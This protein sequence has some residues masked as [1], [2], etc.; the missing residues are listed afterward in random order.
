[1]SATA[2][3]VGVRAARFHHKRLWLGGVL[4]VVAAVAVVAIPIATAAHSVSIS[5]R[6]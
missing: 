6:I 5:R 2:T 1:M 4:A 3:R